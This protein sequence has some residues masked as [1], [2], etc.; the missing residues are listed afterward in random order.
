LGHAV[1]KD[2]LGLDR[3]R[4]PRP[5]HPEPAG[6]QPHGPYAD[7]FHNCHQVVLRDDFALRTYTQQMLMPLTRRSRIH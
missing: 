2:P 3:R 6:D 4:E 7:P 1:W 5:V